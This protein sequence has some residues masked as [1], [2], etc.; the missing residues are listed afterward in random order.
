MYGKVLCLSFKQDYHKIIKE[1]NDKITS[2]QNDR[3]DLVDDY[4]KLHSIHN[5]VQRYLIPIISKG[6]SYLFGTATQSDIRLMWVN[7]DKL[8]NDQKE[9]KTIYINL[10]TGMIKSNMFCTS[11]SD[12]STLLPYH[13]NENKTT[14][15]DQFVHGLSLYNDSTFQ[16]WKPLLTNVPNL[17][18]TD[19]PNE[20]RH[21]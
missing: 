14:I 15:Q 5:E 21:S 10:S 9:T 13:Y 20:T 17:T 16:I 3:R 2:L 7:I 1:L 8:A 12:Y 4:M 6:L 19:I 18:K 11:Q